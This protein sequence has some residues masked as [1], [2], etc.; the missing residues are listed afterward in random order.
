MQPA[1]ITRMRLL[2]YCPRLSLRLEKCNIF[3]SPREQCAAQPRKLITTKRIEI[4]NSNKTIYFN[5]LISFAIIWPKTLSTA[6][7]AENLSFQQNQINPCPITD[8]ATQ[9]SS[10]MQGIDSVS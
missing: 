5:V 10:H 4:N 3:L 2:G 8:I 7:I 9:I 1:G 6:L